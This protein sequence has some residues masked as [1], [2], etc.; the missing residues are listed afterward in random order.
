MT[1]ERSSSNRSMN[2][3]SE[4]STSSRKAARSP[5]WIIAVCST[6]NTSGY[7][8][9]VSVRFWPSATD[10]RISRSNSFSDGFTVDLIRE[11]SERRSGTPEP[12]R[13][14]SWEYNMPRS[15][16]FTRRVFGLPS[17]V[18]ESPLTDIG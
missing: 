13:S 15:A 18:L 12:S 7:C 17:V 16:A 8:F 9:K 1:F 2:P 4:R 11:S 5:A 14:A 3:D 6:G 10:A